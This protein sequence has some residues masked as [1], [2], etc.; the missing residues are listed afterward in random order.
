MVLKQLLKSTI[1]VGAIVV[2]CI[3]PTAGGAQEN[4]LAARL[5]ADQAQAQRLSRQA[6]SLAKE[7]GGTRVAELFG[8]SDE[9]KAARLAA[10]QREQ[11]QSSSI[12]TLNQRVGDLEATLQRLTG[13]MEEL[14]H[15]VGEFNDKIARMRKDFDY[16]IC[17][18][19]AQQLGASAAPGEENALPCGGSAAAGGTAAP[20]AGAPSAAGNVHLA[21]P[22]GALGTLPRGD[23]SQQNQPPSNQ[24]ASIDR[25]PQ[26]EQALTMLARAQYDEARAAFRGFADS[27][28]NDELAPQAV[29][30][31]GDIAFV[32]KDFATAARSFAEEL[33]K[34]PDSPRAADSMLKLGQSLLA[35]N[36]KKEGCRALATLPNQYPAASKSITEQALAERKS[37]SC[38]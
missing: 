20:S 25:R 21:P 1:A 26:F 38:R 7:S 16:K 2:A 6:D 28:P 27:Y 11:A 14:D 30:W 34:Y 32:Q 31:V 8:E 17:A 5:S 37:H 3:G 36:Q 13:Q 33:K 22:P 18:L 12:Y 35:M 15:R 29:Y 19:A 4:D 24:Y 9:E 23:L 10:E